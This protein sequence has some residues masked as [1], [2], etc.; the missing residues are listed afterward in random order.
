MSGIICLLTL[1]AGIIDC[2]NTNRKA[3]ARIP[4]ARRRIAEYEAI[5]REHEKRLEEIRESWKKRD[6]VWGKNQKCGGQS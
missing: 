3:K 6:E 4:E 1:I 5:E 2:I